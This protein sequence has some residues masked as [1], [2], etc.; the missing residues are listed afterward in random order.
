M[1]QGNIVAAA[2][3]IT[4]TTSSSSLQAA[5]ASSDRVEAGSRTP[6]GLN[7][8][9]NIQ[10]PPP[11]PIELTSG[12]GHCQQTDTK[13]STKERSREDTKTI[14]MTTHAYEVN[15]IKNGLL[16]KN[17]GNPTP[18]TSHLPRLLHYK[19]HLPASTKLKPERWHRYKSNSK[20][21]RYPLDDN[22]G[23]TGIDLP[24]MVSNVTT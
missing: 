20:T 16:Y 5:L 22:L 13:D 18:P 1:Q 12:V 10:V 24:Y 17:K 9:P 23:Y 4:V 6:Q 7:L 19:R 8:Q 3:L 2:P 15:S 11:L 21:K 14:L